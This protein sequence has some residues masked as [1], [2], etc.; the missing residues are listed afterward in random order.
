MRK[1]IIA[2]VKEM[3]PIVIVIAV[4]FAA[5]SLYLAKVEATTVMVTGTTVNLAECGGSLG[6]VYSVDGSLYPIGT[7]TCVV[8]K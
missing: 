4:V 5:M 2:L 6:L 7:A 1:R 3:V 8:T